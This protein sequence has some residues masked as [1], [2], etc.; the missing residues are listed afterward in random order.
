M[1]EPN[2]WQSALDG[3]PG[4]PASNH[5]PDS[6]R[7]VHWR[8]KPGKC[9]CPTIHLIA[10]S[11][12]V[13]E[14]DLS[15]FRELGPARLTLTTIANVTVARHPRARL[16]GHL[17][18]SREDGRGSRSREGERRPYG[19]S[20]QVEPASATRSDCATRCRGSAFGISPGLLECITL[21]SA[22]C[23]PTR[24]LCDGPASRLWRC[25][26]MACSARTRPCTKSDAWSRHG[27]K[28]VRAFDRAATRRR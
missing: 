16:R 1:L 4:R 8:R 5:A 26:P 28:R 25:G 9:T 20:L 11:T 2:A 24:K 10:E 19:A 3:S 18:N 7:P 22:D 27:A 17:C 13:A 6:R 23:G 21:R 15:H 14:T 12:T